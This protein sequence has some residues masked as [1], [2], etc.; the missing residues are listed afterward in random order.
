MKNLQQHSKDLTILFVEDDF[1]ASDEI[2]DI[3]S[4]IFKKVIVAIDGIDALNK[5]E[6]EDD[7]DLLLTDINMPRLNGIG[8]IEKIREQNKDIPIIVLS[9][10]SEVNYFLNTIKLGID[11]YILK[12]IEMATFTVVLQ[13]VVNKINLKKE[14]LEYKKN[15]EIQVQNEIEKRLY[16]EK[17][18]I[19]QS[20][21]AAM[22][23]MIDAIAHQWKQ[24]LNIMSL[25]TDMLQYDYED[26]YINKEYID[27]H[28]KKFQQQVTHTLTTLDEFRKFFRPNSENQEFKISDTIDSVLVLVKDEFLKNKIKIE[29]KIHNEVEILGHENEFKHLI[30]NIINNSKDAFIENDIENRIITITLNNFKDSVKLELTDNAG[31]IPL[32]IIDDIFK[33]NIST[34]PIGKGTGIGLYMSSQIA[35]KIDGKLRVENI[36]NGA[37]FIFEKL[38][39]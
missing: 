21:L 14:N 26:G 39:E 20:K 37:K 1:N 25:Q 5:Y 36:D 12:P 16:Q 22:G 33:P 10:H 29:K 24:P 28:I 18:L 3:L 6:A 7:I 11:G 38:Y 8:L 9:A 35:E 17:I 15:L 23:E 27:T 32:D 31:G 4:I 30:L 19:Q 13:N 2:S 34:K